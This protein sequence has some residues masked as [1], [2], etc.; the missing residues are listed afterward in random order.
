MSGRGWGYIGE[1]GD[2]WER[3]DMDERR[4]TE[5]M[6]AWERTGIIGRE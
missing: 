4:R 2:E 1:H 5:D 3:L 6:G